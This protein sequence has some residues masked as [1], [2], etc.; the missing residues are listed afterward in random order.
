MMFLSKGSRVAL[1][2]STLSN[3]PTYFLF[4]FSLLVGVANYIEKLYCDFLWGGLGE[5]FKFYLV[6]W[7]KVCYSIFEGGLGIQNLLKFNC[8]LLG[9]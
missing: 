9:K 3:F 2:K 6:S 5:E 1:I 8:D 7:S 4:L